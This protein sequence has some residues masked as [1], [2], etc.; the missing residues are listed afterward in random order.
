MA[1]TRGQ[2]LIVGAFRFPTGDAAAARVLGIA[3]SL[4]LAGCNVTFGGWEQRE[5]P[6]DAD[7]NGGFAYEGFPYVSQDEF[8]TGRMS[9]VRRLWRYVFAG[10]ATLR[11]IGGMPRGSVRAVI[12]YQGGSLFLLRLLVLCRIRGIRLIADCTEWYAPEGLVGG[13]YGAGHIDHELRMRFVNPLIGRL[14]V[15]SRYLRDYYRRRGGD[16][17]LVPPTVDLEQAKWADVET[18]QKDGVLRL[19][20]A[21]VPARKDVLGSALSGL[22]SLK[23]EGHQVVLHLLGPSRDDLLRCLD[24]DEALLAELGGACVLHGRVP[25]EAVPRLVSRAD[26]S[27]LMRPVT[28]ESAAGFSTKLVES[29]AAGVPVITNPTGDIEHYVKDGREAILLPGITEADFVAGIRRVLALPAEALTAMR[30]H[31]RATAREHFSYRPYA[32]ELGRLIGRGREREHSE[33]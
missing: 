30:A 15:I 7:G 22:R 6:E 19:V 28:R 33:D 9:A 2:V 26:F 25:Q 16:V 23:R 12:A 10:G 17:V 24:G 31:S 21:G 20:Y 14:I 29:L 13:R 11:W 4:R 32:E 8:R 18:P 1:D 5:R 3:K 27:L